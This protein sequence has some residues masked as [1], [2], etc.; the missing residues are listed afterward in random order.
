L[1]AE[2]LQVQ[3]HLKRGAHV[4]YVDDPFA[5]DQYFLVFLTRLV[6]GDMTIE[7]DRTAV[8]PRSEAE[9]GNYD[10]VFRFR[11]GE[12]TEDATLKRNP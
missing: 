7:I 11:H 4:L 12:L 1:S 9:Y 8:H 5:R 2:L 6:Y 10:A 3:P